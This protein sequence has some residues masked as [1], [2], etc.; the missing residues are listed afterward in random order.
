MATAPTSC[1][2][3]ATSCPSPGSAEARR[4][5]RAPCRAPR[6]QTAALLLY[7]HR[8][9]SRLDS[10][11]EGAQTFRTVVARFPFAF[12][13]VILC[14]AGCISP[15]VVGALRSQPSSTPTESTSA[16]DSDSPAAIQ[17]VIQRANTE[18]EQ[19]IAARDSSA[20]RDTS[21]DAYSRDMARVNQ[22]LI[23][24]GVSNIKLL[25]LEWGEIR[26]TGNLAEA[27]TWETWATT[28]AD[29]RTTQSRDRNVYRLVR[30]GADWK[31]Q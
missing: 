8:P 10:P 17:E 9:Y 5:A 25:D 26:V 21:T 13:L 28:D 24:G 22:N 6:L 7:G 4:P 27:T 18:Q 29:G 1:A 14:T 30:E 11:Q 3:K 15:S 12:A 19:A 16:E 2:T 23:D 20:M 31:I